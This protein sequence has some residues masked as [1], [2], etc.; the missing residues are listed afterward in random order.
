[1]GMHPR[2]LK[3]DTGYSQTQ[4]TVDRQFFF[5]PDPAVRNIIGASAARAQKKHPVKIYWLEYNIN[6]EHNGLAAI[7]DSPEHLNNLVKFK[8]TFHRL[9]AE[10]LN[11]YLG[12][13]GAVFATPPRSTECIDDLSLEQQFFYA[14]TNPVKDG[15]VDRVSQ[16]G[17]FSSYK[18]LAKGEV[19]SFVFYNRTAWNKAG[20]KKS[21][22]PLQAFAEVASIEYSP[23]PA[24]EE[25][26]DDKRRALIRREVRKMEQEFREAR[27]LE[28][29]TVM[30]PARLAKT[31]PR[32]RPSS[33]RK[34]T[35]KPL[36]HASSPVRARAYREEFRDFLKARKAA[37][38]LYL[39]GMFDVEFP[40]GS[41]RPPIIAACFPGG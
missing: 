40:A 23:L 35:R 8:Q 22:K 26:G 12:R 38:I 28:G 15:L 7:S 21:K 16:W 4:S 27:E 31:D 20:G 10:G 11:N 18:A 2:W 14:L 34:R 29:R 5:R 37:S 6:H 41:F 3:V 32:D 30:G 24:W 17:G 19:E 9:V 25:M 39:G 13:E 36:C 1:M 33:P